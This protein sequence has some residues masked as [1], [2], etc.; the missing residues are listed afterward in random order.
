MCWPKSRRKYDKSIAIKFVGKGF[1]LFPS[2]L[3]VRCYNHI[4]TLL[5]SEHG[6]V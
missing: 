2:E 4:S 1:P 6:K 3:L 5:V